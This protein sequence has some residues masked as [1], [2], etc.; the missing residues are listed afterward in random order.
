MKQPLQTYESNKM[1]KKYE[2][3]KHKTSL[4]NQGNQ[5]K[6]IENHETTVNKHFS[7]NKQTLASAFYMNHY[8]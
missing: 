3:N 8:H 7:F 6:I 5:P 2:K 4:E 1:Q